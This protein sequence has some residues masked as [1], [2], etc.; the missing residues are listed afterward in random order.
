MP[1]H[2]VSIHINYIIQ[3]IQSFVKM[4]MFCMLFSLL[5]L[6]NANIILRDIHIQNT[7]HCED[8]INGFM[9][10]HTIYFLFQ[11]ETEPKRV[12]FNSCGSEFDTSLTLYNYNGTQIVHCDDCETCPFDPTDTIGSNELLVKTL[13]P[14][15]YILKLSSYWQIQYPDRL[16]TI[17]TICDTPGQGFTL[18]AFGVH[19]PPTCTNYQSSDDALVATLIW[20]H[21]I[22]SGSF[23]LNDINTWFD[24]EN[25]S[26]CTNCSLVPGYKL[27]LKLNSTNGIV[28]DGIR[29]ILQNNFDMSL[30]T[31]EWKTFCSSLVFD[32]GPLSNGYCK[33][34]Y[35]QQWSIICLDKNSCGN[36]TSIDAIITNPITNYNHEVL[37]QTPHSDN[38]TNISREIVEIRRN[39]TNITSFGFH[40]LDGCSVFKTKFN[41]IYTSLLWGTDKFGCD[42]APGTT[43]EWYM[44][45]RDT[46]T[47]QSNFPVF[48]YYNESYEMRITT[49]SGDGLWIDAIK[50]IF[51]TEEHNQTEFIWSRFCSE[52]SF[53]GGPSLTGNC[54]GVNI[55][56]WSYFCLDTNEHCN[57]YDMLHILL[58]YPIKHNEAIIS[59]VETTWPTTPLPTTEPTPQPTLYIKDNS[60]TFSIGFHI[61][62]VIYQQYLQSIP[63]SITLYWEHNVI[64]CSFRIYY[65]EKVPVSGVWQICDVANAYYY[66]I[67]EDCSMNIQYKI[68][69]SMQYYGMYIDQLMVISNNGTRIIWDTFCSSLLLQTDLFSGVCVHWPVK[70]WSQFYTLYQDLQHRH[71]NDDFIDNCEFILSYPMSANN[72]NNEALIQLINDIPSVTCASQ[73]DSYV[74]VYEMLSWLDAEWYCETMFHTSLATINSQ[75]DASTFFNINARNISVFDSV[76]IGLHDIFNQN[77]FYWIDGVTNNTIENITDVELDDGSCVYLSTN[78]DTNSAKYSI[79]DCNENKIFACN[80]PKNEDRIYPYGKCMHITDCWRMHNDC[81]GNFYTEYDSSMNITCGIYGLDYQDFK[82]N[83]KT[84]IH[85]LTIWIQQSISNNIYNIESDD[86]ETVIKAVNNIDIEYIYNNINDSLFLNKPYFIFTV[87]ISCYQLDG[88][89][90]CSK[91]IDYITEETTKW[92]S[93]MKTQIQSTYGGNIQ[94]ELIDKWDIYYKCIQ[95]YCGH[96]SPNDD[97]TQFPAIA[98]WKSKL[99]VF[100]LE[101]IYYTTFDV[102]NTQNQ[103][104]WSSHPIQKRNGRFGFNMVGQQYFQQAESLWIIATLWPDDEFEPTDYLIHVNLITLEQRYRELPIGA[105]IQNEYPC[106]TSDD[107]YVYAVTTQLYGNTYNT[108]VWKYNINTTIWEIKEESKTI[109]DIAVV[110]V[111]CAITKNTNDNNIYI[112][113]GQSKIDYTPSM[114]VIKYN[115]KSETAVTLKTR[116]MFPFIWG[117]A[118]TARNGKIYIFNQHVIEKY[119]WKYLVFN[120][121]TERFESKSIGVDY[122]INFNSQLAVY[123]DNVLLLWTT[124]NG[125]YDTGNYLYVGGPG[126]S[127]LYSLVTDEKAY[128]F[129]QTISTVWPSDG[130]KILYYGSDDFTLFN[131]VDSLYNITFYSKELTDVSITFT[132]YINAKTDVCI[133]ICDPN[134]CFDCNPDDTFPL[135]LYLKPE[136]GHIGSI[137]FYMSA[138][139]N[140]L[141]LPEYVTITLKRCIIEIINIDDLVITD[142]HSS[143][144]FRFNVSDD[145]YSYDARN[146][147]NFSIR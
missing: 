32:K 43:G 50:V 55:K 135:H 67:Y 13:Y 58:S 121:M 44:C 15:R 39:I 42:F 14:G 116:I 95:T 77:I 140:I 109:F 69:I 57:S 21:D 114:N 56:E 54:T 49:S 47:S 136:H 37:I 52:L 126:V 91:I 131:D 89:H 133:T 70:Q 100:G 76:W 141:T 111:A 71:I 46:F 85:N 84:Y 10:N 97:E 20:E 88:K 104:N 113:G 119:P 35:L 122:T 81:C 53:K 68:Q 1:R 48:D 107:H 22:F 65:D 73:F 93:T 79:A 29:I 5:M 30:I 117:R 2:S 51:D 145:C 82:I 147:T 17:S 138:G 134:Q 142:K 27:N 72:D 120:P 75:T 74:I 4:I 66:H 112:F 61:S 41:L 96:V 137:K 87:V 83:F 90:K 99:Y 18:M 125:Q 139:T 7:I 63:V 94:F 144:Q 19:V 92:E 40:V 31:Y 11:L 127:N 45:D 60:T 28:I 102:T 59:L 108:V 3:L 110:K 118:I 86:F 26:K 12:T 132:I 36:Y 103:Y 130:F 78:H 62:G 123:S 80:V 106:L 128:N 105:F 129:I 124:S 38:I 101:N 25:V 24:T 16:Y 115:I 23:I 33:T 146:N 34:W 98:F 64:I 8:V 143:I 9:T 6:S